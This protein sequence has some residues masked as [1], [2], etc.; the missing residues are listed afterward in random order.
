MS[1]ITTIQHRLAAASGTSSIRVVALLVSVVLLLFLFLWRLDTYPT[2]WFDEGAYLNVARTYAQEGIYAEKNVSEYYFNAA[3]VST[4][5]TVILPI[6]LIYKLFG[7]SIVG[8]RL[9]IVLYG[10]ATL[11]FLY[12]LAV[13]L[14]SDRWVGVLVVLLAV[15]GWGNWMPLIYRTIMGEGAG[16]AFL[17]AGLWLWF[18][19]SKLSSGR[20]VAVGLLFGLASITKIQ[21]AFVLFPALAVTC[22]LDRVW[23]RQLRWQDFVVPGAA[24]L[25]I[26]AVWTYYVYFL[27]GADLR[28]P[29]ADLKTVAATGGTTYFLRDFSVFSQNLLFISGEFSGLLIPAVLLGIILSLRRNAQSQRLSV[30]VVLFLGGL[31]FFL[32]TGGTDPDK[33]RTAILVCMCGALFVGM[34]LRGLTRNLHF[35]RAVL[36]SLPH[37]WEELSLSGV[38]GVVAAGFVVVL[39]VLPLF[40]AV[41]NVTKSG[42]DAP[43]QVAHYLETNAPPNALIETWDREMVIISALPVHFPPPSVQTYINAHIRDPRLPTAGEQYDLLKQRTPDYIVIGPS[44]RWAEVYPLSVLEHYELVYSVSDGGAWYEIY[45]A[46]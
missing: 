18:S 39:L 13:R 1:S 41:F 16:L 28:D 8:G 9:V 5:P 22:L 3:V 37:S 24:A 45:Q 17:F 26:L 21:Y 40:R 46:R 30:L 19:D 29:L 34:L 11:A 25:L 20:L 23:Y 38:L 10:F 31:A 36:R 2:P 32:M 7:V 4:G 42:G 12:L 14:S 35:N 43:Y 6:S 33:N 27:L 15:F 44:S